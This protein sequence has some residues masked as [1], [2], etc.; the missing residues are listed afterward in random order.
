VDATRLPR[1]TLAD[2]A[3]MKGHMKRDKK[4]K[5]I[6][7]AVSRAEFLV[8][9]EHELERITGGGG[10]PQADLNKVCW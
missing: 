8:L 10:V 6:P 9:L 5:R 3:S 2:I 7:M 1:Q 4:P